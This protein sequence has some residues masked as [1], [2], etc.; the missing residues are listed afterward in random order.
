MSNFWMVIVISL[1]TGF[2]V[3]NAVKGNHYSAGLLAT[4]AVAFFLLHIEK[5]TEDLVK[6]LKVD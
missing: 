5:I 3:Q 6:K 2:A 1:S 4:M